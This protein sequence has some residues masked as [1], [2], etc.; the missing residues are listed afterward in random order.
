MFFLHHQ[1]KENRSPDI[2]RIFTLGFLKP[3]ALTDSPT[4]C[5]FQEKQKWAYAC[6]C[7]LFFS[8]FSK[9]FLITSCPQWLVE[10]QL[11][12]MLF[13]EIRVI[14]NCTNLMLLPT[15]NFHIFYLMETSMLNYFSP[16]CTTYCRKITHCIWTLVLHCENHRYKPLQRKQRQK[17]SLDSGLWLSGS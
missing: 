15:E 5:S 17:F 16:C 13:A 3:S 9:F 7:F 6:H 11:I 1:D 14:Y 8:I 2:W 10:T 12:I 4:T